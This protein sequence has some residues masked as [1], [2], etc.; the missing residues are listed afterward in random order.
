MSNAGA[1]EKAYEAAQQRYAELGVDTEKAM[2]KLGKVAISLHAWQGDDL[3]GYENTEGLTDGGVLFTG[4]YPGRAS[5]PEQLRGDLEK[6]FSLLPGRHRLNIHAHYLETGGKK[7]DRNEI[8]PEHF[9]GW[10]AWAK[11]NGIGMDFNPM[12]FSH[13]KAESGFTL[14]NYDKDIR[15]FW[16]EHCILCR[17]IAVEMGKQLGSPCVTNVWVP[18]GFKDIPIDRKKSRNIR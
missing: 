17:K 11:Q 3:G 18:D 5:T 12:C 13:P 14:S 4:A 1:V 10:I 16:I 7:V 8:G 15:Q 9:A 6:V 2:E